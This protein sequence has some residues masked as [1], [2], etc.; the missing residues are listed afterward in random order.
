[1]SLNH[2]EHKQRHEELHES[3]DELL[4]DYITH[5]GELL[6]RTSCMTLLMWSHQQT[7]NPTVQD[8]PADAHPENETC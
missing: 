5:T 4:A 3:L 7:M 8:D 1:M 6:G 2:K